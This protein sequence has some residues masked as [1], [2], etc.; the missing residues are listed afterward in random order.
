M[1]SIDYTS[2]DFNSLVTDLRRRMAEAV[3]EWTGYDQGFE[4][5]LFE[6]YAYV[7][8]ILN[9][10]IDRMMNEA[11]LS[12]AALR[13][14]IL[15]LSQMFGYK[16][17]QQTSATCTITLTKTPGL[18]ET[19]IVP[20]GKRV[21]AQVEGADPIFFE[22]TTDV[23]ILAASPSGTVTV[24]EGTSVSEA[25]V[26]VSTGTEQ[27]GMTLYYPRVI[28]D[29]VRVFTKDGT[30][31]PA[32]GQPTLVEWAPFERLIDANFYDRAFTTYVDENQYT[33]IIFGDGV[34]GQIPAVN[35]E[36][37]AT[38]KYGVGSL[39]NIGIG[40]VKG[41]YEADEI[42]AKFASVTNTTA[43][44]GGSDPETI[45]EMRRSIPRSLRS[46][47]RAVTTQDYADTCLQVAG[48]GLASATAAISTN[49]TVYIAPTGGWQV[50]GTG[51]D[52]QPSTNLINIT[53]AY[54]NKRKMIGT[55]VT[56]A[57]PTYVPINITFSV[58]VNGAYLRSRV[59]DSIIA[60]VKSLLAFENRKFG[61]IIGKAAVFRA[62]IDVPGVDYVTIT[63][64]NRD[65][66][67]DD[68]DL[69]MAV[70]EIAKV[71]TITVTAS[72]GLV[73]S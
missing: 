14:S 19:V 50:D 12:T 62:V 5:L 69:T 26:G 37:Y 45:E 47:E 55:T 16:P 7:G 13:E 48:V 59:Q 2:R 24:T 53:Q 43:A 4:T 72:G 67:G 39:G 9:F 28:K 27:Q 63:A 21:F 42:T 68:G 66:A 32:T 36:V 46:L 20:K 40:A 3:P 41:F 49:V 38:Y 23:T 57:G 33:Y 54:I 25:F 70:N 1:P 44:T 65:G 8:D 10:Y 15:N 22:T 29:S 6:N 71:G 64:F 35:V 51:A 31:D 58:T 17:S 11:F 34:S 60:A 56:L 30:I 18:D 61:E 52:G 73:I